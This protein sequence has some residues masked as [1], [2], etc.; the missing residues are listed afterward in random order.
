MIKIKT[1]LIFLK[2]LKLKKHIFSYFFHFFLA[3]PSSLAVPQQ[4]YRGVAHDPKFE[5]ENNRKNSLSPDFNRIKIFF[6]RK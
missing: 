6:D 5:P 3:F 2:R 1:W 4:I